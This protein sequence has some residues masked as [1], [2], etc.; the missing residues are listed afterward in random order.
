MPHRSSGD[1]G[2]VDDF[3]PGQEVFGHLKSALSHDISWCG[4]RGVGSGLAAGSAGYVR[5][6]IIESFFFFYK[7][8]LSLSQHGHRWS[9]LGRRH[10]PINPFAMGVLNEIYDASKEKSAYVTTSATISRN[11]QFVIGRE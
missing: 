6:G 8:I 3:S 5:G 4:H 11:K 1:Q 10:S 2:D 9:A 7:V